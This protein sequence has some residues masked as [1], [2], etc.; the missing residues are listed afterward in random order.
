[1]MH[2]DW[3]SAYSEL[4]VLPLFGD[5]KPFPFLQRKFNDLEGEF[6]PNGQWIAYASDESGKLEVYVQPF[7]KSGAKWM[8]ST[9]GGSLPKWRKDG[10]ELFYLS[11]D[12]KLMAVNIKYEPAF[13]ATPPKALFPHVFWTNYR[14]LRTRFPWP[15]M[16]SVSLFS[17]PSE[18]RNP[19]RSIWCSIGLPA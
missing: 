6:S 5:R 11:E 13:E 18:S 1:M 8:V 12:S 3:N 16:A 19:C 17:H 14:F 2:S 4:W 9:K 10:K 15:L 7:P